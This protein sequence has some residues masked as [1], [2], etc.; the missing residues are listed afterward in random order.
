MGS[1]AV[2]IR[3]RVLAAVSLLA[4]ASAVLLVVVAALDNS[5]GLVVALLGEVVLIGAGWTA[6]SRRG[7]PRAIALLVAAGGL[8][9]LLASI[10]IADVVWWR[11]LGAAVLCMVSVAAA[12]LAL[13]TGIDELRAAPTPGNPVPAAVHPVLLMNPKSGG[14]KAVKFD[15]AG[16]CAARNIEAVVLGRD[17][18]LLKL[19]EDAIADGAD[20]IGM[21]GG[22]GS[23]ALIATVASRH[24]IPHVVV[25]AG[26]RNHFA[27]DLGLD[28]DD[29]VGA[30]DAFGDAVERTIDLATVNGRVFVNNASLGLYAK[31]VQAAEYRDAK[32]RTAAAMLPDLLGPDAQPLD[33]QYTGPDGTAHETAHMVLVSNN[34][35]Q[36]AD[37]SGRGTRE[38]IDRGLLG[39]VTARIEGVRAAEQ[40]VALNAAGQV[41]R[42]SG[43]HEWTTPRFR[44]DS[45]GPVEIGVDGEAMTLDPPLVFESLPAALRVRLPGHAPGVSPAARRISRSTLGELWTT[46]AGRSPTSDVS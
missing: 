21:A 29:V 19:A 44:I 24:G 36:L 6:V 30:L 5:R 31:I 12:R 35:Y 16:E 26:T 2:L 45:G 4:A 37:F 41:R 15:L 25:P 28:R 42:F 40:F 9:L 38:R 17:D 43:W 13:H 14:G 32:M 3:D 39:V 1:R 33:L 20:V 22:D 11:A 18:D 27:L 10:G 23:Q 7:T 34:A 8:A 46:V